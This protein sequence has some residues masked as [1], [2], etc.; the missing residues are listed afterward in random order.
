VAR[1]T[2]QQREIDR[3][4]GQLEPRVAA[5][6][7]DAIQAARRRVDMAALIEALDRGDLFTAIRILEV[8]QAL[9]FP[10]EDAVRQAYISG[11]Q[12][13]AVAA[14]Q[15]LIGFSG[16]TPRALSWLRELSSTRIQGIRDDTLEA[17]RVA[18][19]AGR[20]QG[21]GSRELARMI[22]GTRQGAQR[23]GGIL[24]LTTQQADSIMRGR[25]KLASGDPALM[26]EYLDLK[27]RDRRYD[28]AIKKAI[29]EGRA[30]RGK[31][32]DAILEAHKSKALAYRGRVISKNETFTA[33]EAGRREAVAQ[34]LENPEVAGADKRWQHNL[35]QEPREDHVAMSGTV[36]PF[37]QPFVF[38]DA[39]M[40]Y[41]H[42]P[43]GGA[44]HTIGCRCITVYRIRMK[45]DGP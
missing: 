1:Q 3:L 27:L 45:T 8:P 7:S 31:E 43:A 44:K 5:A 41:A 38:S 33:L 18:L 22:T 9:L 32:L 36:V 15:A 24:G 16:S 39:R 42:D 21:M 35:S 37:D 12:M 10:L 6:F 34:A 25:A 29:A 26:R 13:I 17:V 2:K 20:E 30:I 4:L 40:M 14:P 28:R 23:V 19:I 11:G